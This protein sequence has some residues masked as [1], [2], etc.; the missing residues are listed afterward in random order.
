M[1]QAIIGPVIGAALAGGASIAAAKM[2]KPKG[3]P[4]IS[5]ERKQALGSFAERLAQ[6]EEQLRQG[7]QNSI[8]LRPGGRPI[9]YS[10]ANPARNQPLIFR[11]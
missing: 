8:M 11:S 6:E 3:P 1:P 2:S 9:R 5:K 4:D 7:N 10:S